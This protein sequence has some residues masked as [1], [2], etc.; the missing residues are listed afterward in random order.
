MR[1]IKWGASVHYAKVVL[2]LL[3]CLCENSFAQSTGDNAAMTN[4]DGRHKTSLNGKWQAIIDPY[5]RGT[6][7]GYFKDAHP[8]GKTDFYEYD[9]EK[10]GTLNVPG[11]YNSQTPELKYYESTVW[12]KRSFS[13]SKKDGRAFLHFGAVNYVA[14][15]Y[16]NGSKLGSH[17]GGFTPFQFEVTDKLK[18]GQNTLIL[19]VNNQRRA[20]GLPSLD[21]DWWNYGGITRDVNLVETPATFVEDYFVHV[22][23]ANTGRIEGWVK[24]NGTEKGKTVQVAI[25]ALKLHLSLLPNNDGL[26]RFGA[27]A[28][29]ELWEPEHPKLY[30][31][32]FT[33]G[34]DTVEDKIGFRNIAVKGDE[35]LL[36][37]KSVFLRGVNFHEEIPQRGA[38]AYSAEDALM[39]LNWAKEMGCNF[40][41]LPHYPQNE[42]VLHLA[43]KMG[44]MLW[45]EIP[46]WQSIQFENPEV[47]TKAE[48]FMKE[49]VSRD[50]NRCSV[51]IWSLSNETR[52]STARTRFLMDLAGYTRSLD[53]TRLISSA[54]NN[55]QH[56]HNKI[57]IADSLVKVLDVVG[58]NEYMGWYGTWTTPPGEIVWE[59]PYKKPLIMSEFGAEALYGNHGSKDTTSSW[60]EEYQEQ[61]FKDQITMF[62]NIPF[63]RGVSPW[64]LADFR[65]PIRNLPGKQDGWN[66]KGLISEKGDK[67]KAWYVVKAWYDELKK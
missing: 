20:D 56:E 16:L 26:A 46:I 8:K 7:R 11:D 12:Y 65:S 50:R 61:V 45:E 66:R 15:V 18:S 58:V 19:R 13:Y 49:M 31:V 30:D 67:K 14:D 17:E 35:I 21:Y 25:P 39:M 3:L 5:D 63:L 57:T 47:K 54:L 32:D 37:G 9:F 40:V 51:I 2:L 27:K 42:Y 41:R 1:T 33:C 43:D 23:S 48:R 55:V 59:N 24:L 10:S 62:K 53:T 29:P 34:A 4:I 22:A 38:R 52:S 28:R 36:N 60:S 64:V 6:D 44:I